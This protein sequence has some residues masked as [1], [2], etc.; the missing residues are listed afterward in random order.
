VLEYF[1]KLKRD[2]KTVVFVSHDMNAIREYCDQAILIENSRIVASGKASRVASEYS[3][4]FINEVEASSKE[5]EQS[6]A[7]G[8]R[9]GDGAVSVKAI[10]LKQNTISDGD[11]SLGFTVTLLAARDTDNIVSGFTIKDGFGTEICGMNTQIKQAGHISLQAAETCQVEWKCANVFADGKCTIDLSVHG[12]DGASVH[13]WWE[14]AATFTV[15]RTEIT[16]YRV[17]P[18][19]EVSIKKTRKY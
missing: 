17:L 15:K 9:W 12:T 5:D 13:D 16:A 7:H 3:R 14:G 2:K 8:N 19:I 6:S 1:K 11:E 18:P 10:E 4:L